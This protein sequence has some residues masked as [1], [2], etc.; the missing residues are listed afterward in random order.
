MDSTDAERVL[1][2][3]WATMI[4]SLN[5]PDSCAGLPN[6]AIWAWLVKQARDWLP[7]NKTFSGGNFLLSGVSVFAATVWIASRR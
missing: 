2:S 4:T 1:G 5:D 3:R 6:W 7:I